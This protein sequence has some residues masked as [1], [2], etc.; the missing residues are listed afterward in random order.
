MAD[1]PKTD[2]EILLAK[3]YRAIEAIEGQAKWHS[4]SASGVA[5]DIAKSMNDTTDEKIALRAMWHQQYTNR[6][7][8]EKACVTAV[9]LI[10]ESLRKHI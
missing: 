2:E 8:A 10:K 9:D 6:R 3:I 4:D 5:N 7:E 1:E